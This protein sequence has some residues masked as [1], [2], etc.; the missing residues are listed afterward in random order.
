M[1]PINNSLAADLQADTHLLA[2]LFA[3]NIDA[4]KAYQFLI[5]KGYD[6]AD[7]TL[8]MSEAT[9]EKYFANTTHESELETAP[10]ASAGKGSA[11]GG[12][13]GVTIGAILGITLAIG[14]NFVIPGLGFLVAGPLI[15]GLAGAGTVGI[16]GGLIGALTGVGL[17]EDRAQLYEQ[18]LKNGQILVG[19]HPKVHDEESIH[20]A[21]R[22]IGGK[23][24]SMRE[25][26]S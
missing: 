16:A 12:S 15:A 25:K 3:N 11:I 8:I 22:I 26:V 4:E 17:G 13:I 5:E 20:Q 6:K 24:I 1:E 18:N 10:I 21:W 9:R 23:E 2:A 19:I 7:I 14:T